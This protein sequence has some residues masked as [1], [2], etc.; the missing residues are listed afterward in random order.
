MPVESFISFDKRKKNNL[1]ER[2]RG[3]NVCGDELIEYLSWVFS[4][5]IM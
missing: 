1:R 2:E 5:T 4:L 3:L